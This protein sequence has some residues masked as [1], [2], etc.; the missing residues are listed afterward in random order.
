MDAVHPEA[1]LN[2]LPAAH[3]Q[4]NFAGMME[5]DGELHIPRN[6]LVPP[7]NIKNT[8]GEFL[9]HNGISTFA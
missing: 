5:Y 9:A 1:R 6:Y 3:V 7:P 2:L 8:S 4:V